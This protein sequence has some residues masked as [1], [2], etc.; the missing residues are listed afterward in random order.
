MNPN[1][2][3]NVGHL[4]RDINGNQRLSTGFFDAPLGFVWF[5]YDAEGQNTLLELECATGTYKG[6]SME[7]Y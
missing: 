5:K 2:F 1:V 3:V 7:A 6:V 4:F